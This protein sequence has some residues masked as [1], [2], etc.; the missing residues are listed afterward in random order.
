MISQC[1]HDTGYQNGKE[2]KVR[3]LSGSK[4]LNMS[5]SVFYITFSALQLWKNIMS[6]TSQ[7]VYSQNHILVVWDNTPRRWRVTLIS[8]RNSE[9]QASITKDPGR[10]K[11]CFLSFTEKFERLDYTVLPS[12]KWFGKVLKSP[13]DYHYM[14]VVS[15]RHSSCF[16]SVPVA[17]TCWYLMVNTKKKCF[18]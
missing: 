5:Q 15:R 2:V 6:R 3:K 7:V 18:C 11:S 9:V 8:L 14:E 12:F 10:K 17:S 13:K 16:T 4:I 1:F